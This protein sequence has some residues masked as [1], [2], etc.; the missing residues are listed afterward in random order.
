[1]EEKLYL[2]SGMIFDKIIEFSRTSLQLAEVER[3]GGISP[4]VSPMTSTIKLIILNDRYKRCCRFITEV[5]FNSN[6]SVFRAGFTLTTVDLDD[7][8]VNYPSMFELMNDL[9]SMGENNSVINR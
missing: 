1:M 7:I 2:N 8:V 6:E 5:S 4:H 3:S 9:Q